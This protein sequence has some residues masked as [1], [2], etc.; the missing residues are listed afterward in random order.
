MAKDLPYFKFFVSEWSDGDVTLESLNAQGLFINVCSYY[1]SNE[2]E[3]SLIKLKKKFRGHESLIDDLVAADIVKVHDGNVLISFL[4]EQQQERN[5]KSNKNR[6][7]ALN[8]WA[9]RKGSERN[10]NA[11]ET[12]SESDTIKR[13]EEEIRE[14][15]EIVPTAKAVD[16]PKLLEYINTTFTREF[17]IINESIKTKYKARIKEGYTKKDIITAIDN[18]RKDKYH[19]ET[20]F[21]Y[22]TPEFF[23]RSLTIDKYSLIAQEVKSTDPLVEYAREHQKLYDNGNS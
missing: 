2:C 4:I 19:I 9:K 7:I 22:C 10:T 1:W 11:S 23:S 8:A 12:Q 14:D 5:A 3:V 16:Y 20:N 21:K 15:K 13:R 6:E 18:C 17:R